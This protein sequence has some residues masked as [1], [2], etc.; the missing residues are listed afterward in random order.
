[1]DTTQNKQGPSRKDVAILCSI[2]ALALI[3]VAIWTAP[4]ST[5]VSA[6]LAAVPFLAVAIVNLR[7]G[8]R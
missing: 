6:G 7:R 4:W 8:N 3:Q 5:A 2:I 1:M